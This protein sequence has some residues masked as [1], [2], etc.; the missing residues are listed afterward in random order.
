MAAT[1]TSARRR[2]LGAG[3]CTLSPAGGALP[4]TS[5]RPS[6]STDL[7]ARSRWAVEPGRARVNPAKSPQGRRGPTDVLARSDVEP[8]ALDLGRQPRAT[9]RADADPDLYRPARHVHPR[10]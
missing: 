2:S 10:R 4:G 8:R 6:Q 9:R 1:M 3:D 7:V 5:P